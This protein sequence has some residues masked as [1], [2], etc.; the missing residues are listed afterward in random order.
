MANF[1]IPFLMFA[2]SGAVIKKSLKTFCSSPTSCRAALISLVDDWAMPAKSRKEINARV[3][4]GKIIFMGKTLFGLYRIK[5]AITALYK[6][7]QTWRPF[8]SEK[9]FETQE[10]NWQVRFAPCRQVGKY[11][12]NH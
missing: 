7:I 6:K 9:T 10:F 3:K 1:C 8:L 2:F 4:N 11:F 12:A 5:C